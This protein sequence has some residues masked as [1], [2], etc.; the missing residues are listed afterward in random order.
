MRA[1]GLGTAEGALARDAEEALR[2]AAEIGTPV[3]LKGIS[4][5]VTHRAAAGLLAIDLRDEAAILEG[6][7]RL[8]SRAEQIGAKLDGVLVQRMRPRGFELIVSAFRDPLYGP[9]ISVGAGGGLTELIDDVTI[10]R[11]PVSAAFAENMI[12]RLRSRRHARDETGTLPLAPAAE[13]V[14]AFSALTA[15]A[16][17]KRYVFEVNPIKWSRDAAFAVDGLLIIEEA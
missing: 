2:I 12:E 13:F 1:F 6:F 10:A 8:T 11:A 7:R 17:W 4:P 15:T 9:M 5:A 3:V 16:P 14:S